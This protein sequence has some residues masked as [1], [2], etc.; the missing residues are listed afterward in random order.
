MDLKTYLENPCPE[1]LFDKIWGEL[2][3][4]QEKFGPIV[5]VSEDLAKAHCREK[6][7]DEGFLGIPVSVKDCI[8]AKGIRT[9]AGSR[10]LENYIPPF[11]AHVIEEI[12]KV[13]YVAAKTAMDEFGF[14]TF[15]MNTSF[16]IP[17]NPID[18]RRCCGGSSGGA[19]CLTKAIELPH[20]ALA[21]STGGSIACPASFCGVVG[22]TPT[23]G[24]ASRYGLIDYASSL[25][26]IGVMGKTCFEAAY[27]LSKIA[28]FDAR[29][30]TSID[31]P[32][33][34]YT[35]SLKKNLSG[36]RIGVPKEY[37]N[38]VDE[39][40][41]KEVWRAI[42]KL[43][44]LGAEYEEFSLPS[45]KYALP[46]YYIIAMSEAS[47]NLAKFCG[48]RYGSTIELKGGYNEFFSEA[49]GKYFGTEAKR[50]CL[51]GTF[52]R[53]SGYRDKY[54]LKALKVRRLLIDEFKGA[55]RKY[56]ALACPTMPIIAP[57]FTEVA[58]LSPARQ[59]A[60]DVLTVGPNLCG[61][62]H[63]SVPCG[64]SEGMPVGLQI[65]GDHLQEGKV[66]KLGSWV[67]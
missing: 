21:E 19:A 28:G 33:E 40:I 36:F 2:S 54:Y 47:T 51:M 15:C 11:D 1:A 8:C 9:A 23:Y 17:K 59:Y 38:G 65:I 31:K 12:K 7:L 27:G 20:I 52:Y 29:D 66:F 53:K 62:P 46:A 48:I 58:E 25:D 60:M 45:T 42:K 14:G 41:K 18:T 35:Q 43:E 4:I 32:K 22:M 16:G 10:I 44:S 37:F 55:F 6:A 49:R 3:Q 39:E 13:G 34:D 64:K 50:R 5:A 61:L 30:S 26:K 63:L 24:R 57:K 67:E 56:D